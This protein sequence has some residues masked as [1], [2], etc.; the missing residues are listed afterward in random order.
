MGVQ[1]VDLLVKIMN[2]GA[3]SN[4]VVSDLP[5]LT[6]RESSSIGLK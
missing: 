4:L 3:P 6:I 1:A 5:A 2:G